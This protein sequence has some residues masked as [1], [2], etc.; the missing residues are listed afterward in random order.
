[1]PVGQ[2]DYFIAMVVV[3]IIFGIS[4]TEVRFDRFQSFFSRVSAS[5]LFIVIG[6][7]L[8]AYIQ[9]EY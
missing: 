2:F 6:Y 7:R 8:A 3:A 5:P 4:H 1:M 9:H